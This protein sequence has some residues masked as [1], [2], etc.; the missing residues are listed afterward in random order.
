M[1]KELKMKEIEATDSDMFESFGPGIAA[2]V[3]KSN[4]KSGFEI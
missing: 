4:L 1:Q 3:L 2:S